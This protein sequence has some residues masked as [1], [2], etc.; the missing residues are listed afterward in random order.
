MICPIQIL[1]KLELN[2][3]FCLFQLWLKMYWSNT[4][5]MAEFVRICHSENWKEGSN[6]GFNVAVVFQMD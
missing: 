6:L 4:V 3:I 2:E 1:L 5:L